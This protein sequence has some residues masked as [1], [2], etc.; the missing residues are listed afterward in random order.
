MNFI[1]LAVYYESLLSANLIFR[2]MDWAENFAKK[3]A[4]FYVAD[5]QVTIKSAMFFLAAFQQIF[6]FAIL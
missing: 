3:S 1:P 6:N 4:N 5:L 2:I